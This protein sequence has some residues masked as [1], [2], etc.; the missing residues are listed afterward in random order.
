MI[1]PMSKPAVAAGLLVVM[2]GAWYWALM[3]SV[4]HAALDRS[5]VRVQATAPSSRVPAVR[6]GALADRGDARPSAGTRRNPFGVGS[7]VDT[8][9]PQSTDSR[10]RPNH[11]AAAAEE[12]KAPQWP[13]LELIGLAEARE[14]G[15]V[16]RTAII[17]VPQG[18]LHASPGDVLAGVYRLERIGADGVDVRLLPEDRVLRVP[19]RR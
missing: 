16:V 7:Q 12:P 2:A 17:S 13:R 18:V 9:T 8:T 6:L 10:P 11:V 1:R 3:P 14:G 4:P 5:T 15:A 19:L